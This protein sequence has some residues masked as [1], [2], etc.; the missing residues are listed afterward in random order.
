MLLSPAGKKKKRRGKAKGKEKAE[1]GPSLSAQL[2]QIIEE[3]YVP[4]VPP[5]PTEPQAT[6]AVQRYRRKQPAMA[7]RAKA[8]QESQDFRQLNPELVF[9]PVGEGEAEDAVMNPIGAPADI[10]F[11]DEWGRVPCMPAKPHAEFNLSYTPGTDGGDQPGVPTTDR[12]GFVTRHPLRQ[13]VVLMQNTLANSAVPTGTG[14]PVYDWIFESNSGVDGFTFPINQQENKFLRPA[15]AVPS[16]AANDT[17]TGSIVSNWNVHGPCLYPGHDNQLDLTTNTFGMWIDASQAKPAKI[18]VSISWNPTAGSTQLFQLYTWDGV[19]WVRYVNGTSSM[20]VGIGNAG[21]PNIYNFMT[22]SGAGTTIV[23]SGYY[24]IRYAGNGSA[25]IDAAQPR[26]GT[27]R[28]Q[29]QSGATDCW[30]HVPAVNIQ[31]VRGT[32]RRIKMIGSS[33]R[34]HNAQPKG[35]T[36]GGLGTSILC[37]GGDW[38]P[39]TDFIQATSA[40]QTTLSTVNGLPVF[41][42][43][44]FNV[45]NST[46]G[47]FSAPW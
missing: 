44:L 10:V 39:L 26:N 31:N 16:T 32:M 47:T 9:R 36:F 22:D 20:A 17:L 3:G 6:T 28:V 43:A 33:F 30:A 8:S 19:Q 41:S 42:G 25:T 29:F 15:W 23:N 37:R 38:D 1:G 4:L 12:A 2:D 34:I 18:G 40:A 14:K 5:V 35:R 21:G 46:E 27:C 24:A 45:I 11:G 7:K 13:S